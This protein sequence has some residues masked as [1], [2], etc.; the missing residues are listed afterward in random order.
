MPSREAVG[1]LDALGF[2]EHRPHRGA[3]AIGLSVEDLRE[4]YAARLVL[5][6]RA[7]SAAASRFADDEAERAAASLTGTVRAP[8]DSDHAAAS[9]GDTEFHFAPH[10]AARSIWLLRLIAPPWGTSKRYRRPSLSAERDFTER[11][12]EHM[13]ILDA[14]ISRDRERAAR[15]LDEH[16]ARSA[17]RLAAAVGGPSLSAERDVAP[18][19]PPRSL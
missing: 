6:A 4:V 17:D 14:S 15:S 5:E 12:Q 3:R 9:E 8:T 16:F 7:V 18:L 11:Y 19:P 10:R 2:V 13:S 1:Q